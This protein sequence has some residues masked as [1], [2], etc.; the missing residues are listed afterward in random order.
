MCWGTVCKIIFVEKRFGVVVMS[1][2]MVC[3]LD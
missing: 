1:G 2:V 3:V